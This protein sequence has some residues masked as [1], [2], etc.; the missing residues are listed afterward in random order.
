MAKVIKEIDWNGN[1]YTFTNTFKSTGTKSHDILTMED[2]NGNSWVGE[3]TWI[4]RPW[5][6]FDLEEAF[7]EIVSKAF[8]PKALAMVREIDQT[9][10]SVEQVIETFFSKLKP[11]DIQANPETITDTSADARLLALAKYLEVEPEEVEEVGEN[12]FSVNGDT[13]RVLTDEE[14]D[15]DFDERVRS[16][17]DELGLDEIGDNFRDYVL[18]N[19]IDTDQLEDLVRDDISDYVYNM[20][21]EEVADECIDEGIVESEEVYDE[22][23][24]EWSP[25][26]RDDVDFDDLREQLI[27]EKFNQV[28]DYVEY[29]RDLG[30]DAD[31]FKDYIDEEAVIDA[32]KDDI[33]VNGGGRGQELSWVNGEEIELDNGFYAYQVD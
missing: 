12:E 4:N 19:C 30:Y 28:D 5:H 6:R 23:S 16:L 18:E 25:E 27:D 1:H 7:D 14:A 9:G 10:H 8:G 24:D 21:D 2:Q 13:Y 33:D 20:S 31:F 22:E 3:T 17:W 11:E 32:L 29:F 15:Y 26:L